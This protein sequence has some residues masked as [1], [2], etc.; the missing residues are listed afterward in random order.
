[1]TRCPGCEK[2]EERQL[3]LGHLDPSAH[4]PSPH[5]VGG[6]R[7]GAGPQLSA[8][9]TGQPWPG[10]SQPQLLREGGSRAA[11]GRWE[12][13]LFPQA[14]DRLSIGVLKLHRQNV[15]SLGWPIFKFFIHLYKWHVFSFVLSF[16]YSLLCLCKHCASYIVLLTNLLQA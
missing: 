16:S 12:D 8:V 15:S 3:Q 13:T 1:M 5:L 14:G 7:R 11:A 9:S 6:L 4:C 2:G 10:Q